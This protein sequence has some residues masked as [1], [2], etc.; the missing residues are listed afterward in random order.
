[1]Y[2]GV[3]CDA[4]DNGIP[5]FVE[6]GL[7]MTNVEDEGNGDFETD[8]YIILNFDNATAVN[9]IELPEHYMVDGADVL[10]PVFEQ[11]ICDVLQSDCDY[12]IIGTNRHATSSD[13][14]AC[15]RSSPHL[16]AHPPSPPPPPW[17]PGH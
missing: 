8:A 15:I 9:L 2:K 10:C 12:I 17:I 3:M 6:Y 7:F 14:S 13:S 5:L 16:P 11:T 4:Y 1:M